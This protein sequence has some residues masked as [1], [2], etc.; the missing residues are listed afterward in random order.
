MKKKVIKVIIIIC[1]VYGIFVTVDCIRLKSSSLGSKP[2]ICLNT[3]DK[4]DGV[5]YIGLGYTLTYYGKRTKFM[6]QKYYTNEKTCDSADA[7][8]ITYYTREEFR[9]FDKITI[10]TLMYN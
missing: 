10:W 2:I 1:I 4:E 3:I 9:L 6:G 7:D 8:C 5:K